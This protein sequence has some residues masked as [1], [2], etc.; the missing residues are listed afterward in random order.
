MSLTPFWPVLSKRAVGASQLRETSSREIIYRSSAVEKDMD[1]P[2]RN[3]FLG[4][5]A[6]KLFFTLKSIYARQFG[7]AVLICRSCES[8]PSLM[9]TCLS[10]E[11]RPRPNLGLSRSLDLKTHQE[12]LY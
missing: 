2:G 7:I 10:V 8:L 6:V 1:A 3:R 5:A 4:E 11:R 12:I 9:D